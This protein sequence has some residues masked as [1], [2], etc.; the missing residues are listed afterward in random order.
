MLA[1]PGWVIP[2]GRYERRY[3][4]L[5]VSDRRRE[6]REYFRALHRQIN[7]EGGAAA[8]MWDLQRMDFGD[9]HPREIP[10]SLLN[11]FSAATPASLRSPTI[12]AVVLRL[13]ERRQGTRRARQQQS[14]EQENLV[15]QHCLHN[16]PARRRP[17]TLPTSSLGAERQH[18]RRRRDEPERTLTGPATELDFFE[19]VYLNENLRLGYRLKAA[20]ERAKYTTRSSALW[21]FR[22]W[23]NTVSRKRSN[24]PSCAAKDL[25]HSSAPSARAAPGERIE[26]QLSD[27]K[28]QP[29]LAVETGC[30]RLPPHKTITYLRC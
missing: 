10:Q 19:A 18:A 27:A 13:A 14:A 12:G 16:E 28:A 25:H 3:A 20:A 24:A 4:A 23:I 15:A 6:D 1:E 5:L 21:R 11:G 7:Q 26:G 22:R 17:R 8:M 9:W 2:A 29:S 30:R